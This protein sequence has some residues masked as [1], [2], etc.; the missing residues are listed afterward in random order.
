MLV[1]RINHSAPDSESGINSF[2]RVSPLH[3]ESERFESFIPHQ[4]FMPG[5]PSGDGTCIVSMWET[6]GGSSPSPGSNDFMA[7]LCEMPG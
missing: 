3:G 2:G 7:I 6:H 1:V 5:W 4:A